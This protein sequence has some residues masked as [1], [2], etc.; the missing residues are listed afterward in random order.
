MNC[1]SL[2][3]ADATVHSSRIKRH[4]STALAAEQPGRDEVVPLGEDAGD[5]VLKFP[6][7]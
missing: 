2:L 4:P 5:Q 7:A 1:P 6:D 3:E